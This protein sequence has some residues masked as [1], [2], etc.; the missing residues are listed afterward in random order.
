[1]WI[2]LHRISMEQTA[3]GLPSPLCAEV[4]PSATLTVGC[5]T[6]EVT[7]QQTDNQL[8]GSGVAL[9]QPLQVDVSSAL[10]DNLS[11]PD[12][13]C[14]RLRYARNRLLLGPIIGL[15]LG[16]DTHRYSPAFMQ[17]FSDRLGVYQQVGGLICAFSA[18]AIDFTSRMA[19]GLY[20]DPEE[21][22]WRYGQFPLPGVIYRRNF[23]TGQQVIDRLVGLT[24]G[25][26]FNSY[27]FDKAELY[28]FLAGDQTLRQYL[29][30]WDV[31]SDP[32][33]VSVFLDR[34][35]K[36]VLKPMDLSRGRGIC[37]LE[38][39][40]DCVLVH[41]YRAH[42]P[43]R[44][45]LAGDLGFRQWLDQNPG[46]FNRYLMQ[47][48]VQLA[49]I[50]GAHYDVRLV[51]QKRLSLKWECSGIE[52]RVGQS[53]SLLT[54]ISRGGYALTLPKALALSFPGQTNNPLL[55]RQL[56]DVA[57]GICR[58][59]DQLGAHFAELGL[60]LAVDVHRRVWII[61]ANVFPSFKGFKRTSQLT[62][63]AIRHAP[64]LYALHLSGL[65]QPEGG[66][67]S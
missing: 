7:I 3:I 57:L 56:V 30:P 50:A 12:G 29:P 23:H 19:A 51:M 27:R 52:C 4:G 67:W 60:D 37:I 35:Q 41:D 49:T 64:L 38:K 9:E 31:A 53:N 2:R 8:T 44:R 46:L 10:L 54:N 36:A 20:Y 40:D 63:L 5:R 22:N 28:A 32:V 25:R 62:Y 24:E 1:M 26:L 47:G 61:E 55:A 15:L 39:A 11:L 59:L 42:L 18:E 14:Y 43:V 17:K 48:Y 13:L 45:E 66:E 21:D 58:R 33:Q 34:H 6:Q 16:R 65:D